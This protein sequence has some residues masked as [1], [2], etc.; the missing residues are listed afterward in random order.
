MISNRMSRKK[1]F[2]VE[3]FGL[4]LVFVTGCCIHICDL[5]PSLIFFFVVLKFLRFK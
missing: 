1:E 3:Y 5:F 2:S 4:M